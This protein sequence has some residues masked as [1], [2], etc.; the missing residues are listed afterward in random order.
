[1]DVGNSQ[2]RMDL[3]KAGDGWEDRLA[4][5]VDKLAAFRDRLMSGIEVAPSQ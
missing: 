5:T 3:D 2:I 1:M 4:Q